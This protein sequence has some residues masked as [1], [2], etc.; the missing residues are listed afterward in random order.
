MFNPTIQV[1]QP[2]YQRNTLTVSG[3][4]QLTVSPDEASVY[5]S[6]VSDNKT[7]K[8]AQENDRTT[9]DAVMAAL[10]AAGLNASD[11]ET[12]T[13]S[14]SKL[15]EYVPV[16]INVMPISEKAKYVDRGYRLTHTIKATTKHTESVGD[17]IDAA[18]AAGANGV[19]SITFG[20][21]KET[22]KKVRD[23]ALAK[24]TQAAKEKAQSLAQ[25][26]GAQ[27]GKVI[28]INEQNFY[29]TP[30][31]YNVRSNVMLDSA[32]GAVPPTA[33]SPQKVEVT[34]SVGLVY[35]IK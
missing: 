28:T 29:Y 1:Q 24:A 19:D 2:D 32:S 14:L 17:I 21:T 33:I 30:Y 20:L 16:D 6:V 22:E 23:D 9:S 34:S 11:I 4:A 5:I 27:L 35:E 15:D 25:T 13:Y 12:Q 31:E 18:V 8:L 26:A 7:A 3:N 10:R